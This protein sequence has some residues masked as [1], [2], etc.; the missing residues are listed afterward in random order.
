MCSAGDKIVGEKDRGRQHAKGDGQSVSRFHMGGAPE[1][2]GNPAAAKEKQE[3]NGGDIGLSTLFGRIT[4][5]QFGPQVETHAFAD[6]GIRTG[7]EGL[8]C[9][10][11][12]RGRDDDAGNDEPGRHDIVKRVAQ[13]CIEYPAVVLGEQ[14]RALAQ[15][16]QDQAYLNVDPREPDIAPAAVTQVGIKCLCA[17][18]AKEDCTQYPESF[19]IC[20]QQL[21]GIVGAEGPEDMEVV[22]QVTASQHSLHG[23]PYKHDRSEKLS[24]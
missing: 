18:S 9:N 23:K 8:A 21:D 22:K 19:W 5:P 11:G 3:I 2:Q 10:D 16:I 24:D 20:C 12:R 14:P 13:V 17:G 7:D 6:Q 1:I 4:D 15:V